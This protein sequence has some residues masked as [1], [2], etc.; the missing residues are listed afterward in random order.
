M[1]TNSLTN[2]LAAVGRQQISWNTPEG[3]TAIATCLGAL[4]ALVALISIVLLRH[5]IKSDHDRSRRERAVDLMT[6]FATSQEPTNREVVFGLDLLHSL[7][8]EQCQALWARDSF[9]IEPRQQHMLDAYRFVVA[10]KGLAIKKPAGGAGGNS[11]LALSVPEVLMLRSL[12]TVSLNKLE[13]IAS[14]W[15][16]NVADKEMLAAEFVRV[17]CPRDG[18]YVL[19]TFRDASGIYPSI[20][21]FCEHY[22]QRKKDGV[23][24]KP[25]LG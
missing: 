24:S 10:A 19:E 16:N 14:A 4:F 22:K 2:T 6:C 13:L 15:N 23:V 3:V 12:A 21:A 9:E 8:K 7:T 11:V 5:Q 1:P 25:P 17:F 20:A 18:N